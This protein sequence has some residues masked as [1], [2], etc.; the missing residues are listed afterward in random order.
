MNEIKSFIEQDIEKI[1]DEVITELKSIATLDKNHHFT[2]VQFK[3]LVNHIRN[4]L[5]QLSD[6][7]DEEGAISFSEDVLNRMEKKFQKQNKKKMQKFLK[8][9]N[10]NYTFPHKIS[11]RFQYMMIIFGLCQHP[12][13]KK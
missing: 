4:E 9:S 3:D 2:L 13:I 10:I 5:S 1:Y 8:R 7:W 11:N 6:N 12:M